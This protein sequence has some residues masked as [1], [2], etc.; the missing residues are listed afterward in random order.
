MEQPIWVQIREFQSL[1]TE[2]LQ[3]VLTVKPQSQTFEEL[4]HEVV[5]NIGIRKAAASVT[6]EEYTSCPIAQP[7]ITRGT[8]CI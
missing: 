8:K 7:R 2:L 1:T 5:D 4:L 3:G 6:F